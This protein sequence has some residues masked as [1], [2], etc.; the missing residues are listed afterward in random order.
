M[1][2]I[3]L[4]PKANV[5]SQKEKNLRQKIKIGLIISS[6]VAAFILIFL[7][8]INGI[9]AVRLNQQEQKREDLMSQF[10]A[11][12]QTA[13]DLRKL[14]DKI[15]GIKTVRGGQTDFATMAASVSALLTPGI[16]LKAMSLDKTGK[17]NLTATAADL[18]SLQVFLPGIKAPF[19]KIILSGL[20]LTK[21]NS[22]DF[23]LEMTYELA[24]N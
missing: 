5:L 4:L 17:V 7:L 14:K 6:S 23:S 10:A 11:Q 8:I 24:K 18:A 1:I 22:L 2:D 21:N 15:F 13:A 20:R 16:N 9:L 19:N 3:N 12:S